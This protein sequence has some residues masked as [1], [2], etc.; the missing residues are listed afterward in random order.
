M[1]NREVREK[2]IGIYGRECMLTSLP[3]GLTY[4]HIW[5]KEHGG[6]NTIDN[7]AIICTEAHSWLHQQERTELYDLINECLQLYKKC[8]ELGE[9]ELVDQY[10]NDVKPKI[11]RKVRK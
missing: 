2:M 10:N 5:K 6:G 7:G 9:V 11:K 1:S 3:F 4:H 8:V